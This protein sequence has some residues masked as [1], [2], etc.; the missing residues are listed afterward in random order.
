MR[1]GRFGGETSFDG[2]RPMVGMLD[3]LLRKSGRL[4]TGRSDVP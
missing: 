2:K 4:M 1:T 3:V